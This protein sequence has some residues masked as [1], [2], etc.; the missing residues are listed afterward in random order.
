MSSTALMGRR[1]PYR[2]QSQSTCRGNKKE[3]EDDNLSIK[4]L[5]AN[6]GGIPMK[7]IN[8][9]NIAIGKMDRRK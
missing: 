9:K 4:I 1:D 2:A 7:N 6:I 5:F 8:N 3:T